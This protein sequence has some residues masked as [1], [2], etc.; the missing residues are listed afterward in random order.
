MHIDYVHTMPTSCRVPRASMPKC[1]LLL[2]VI[3]LGVQGPGIQRQRPLWQMITPL[4]IP[5]CRANKPAS[6]LYDCE[7]TVVLLTNSRMLIR[8]DQC[9]SPI[10]VFAMPTHCCVPRAA[11]PKCVPLLKVIVPGV[12]DRW[13]PTSAPTLAN[14]HPADHPTMHSRRANQIQPV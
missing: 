7:A 10:Y 5:Q 2:M 9:T 3:K 6:N 12:P 13:A 4:T 8:A 1:K 11:M 14:E